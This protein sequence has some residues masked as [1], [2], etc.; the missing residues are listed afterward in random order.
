MQNPGSRLL[1]MQ[2]ADGIRAGKPE[3]VALVHAQAEGLAVRCRD[4]IEN[5]ALGGEIQAGKGVFF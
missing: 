1:W 2:H 4:V 5:E 3:R